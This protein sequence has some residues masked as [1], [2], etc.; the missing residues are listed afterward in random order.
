MINWVPDAIPVSLP[1]FISNFYSS[2]TMWNYFCKTNILEENDTY[3]TVFGGQT[4]ALFKAN[5]LDS[6]EYVGPFFSSDMPDV[7]QCLQSNMCLHLYRG[8]TV[9]GNA[10]VTSMCTACCK[11]CYLPFHVFH[12][13]DAAQKSELAVEEQ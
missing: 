6:W 3:Y 7:Q 5:E 8:G 12:P 1:G 9:H 4:P 11:R 13:G 10:S 2:I